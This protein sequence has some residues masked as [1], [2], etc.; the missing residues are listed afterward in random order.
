MLY[1]DAEMYDEATMPVVVS[2][3]AVKQ[4]GLV[5]ESSAVH[6]QPALAMH[7]PV[8]S[9]AQRGSE[10]QGITKIV[11]RSQGFATLVRQ[12][13]THDRS[14][15]ALFIGGTIQGLQAVER[16]TA[17]TLLRLIHA[18]SACSLG[19][20]AFRTKLRLAVVG[21]Y[22]ANFKAEREVRREREWLGL[23]IGCE[24]HMVSGIH[25]KALA[26]F[27]SSISG[28]I[29]LSLSMDLAG[30]M[31]K[32]RGCLRKVILQRVTWPPL[33]G[34]PS[35]EA[36]RYRIHAIS[37][38]VVGWG[39]AS[40]LQRAAIL[41][42]LPMGDWRRT[43]RVEVDLSLHH[44]ELPDKKAFLT[45]FADS[46]ANGLSW[47]KSAKYPRH[48]WFGAEESI[49]QPCLMQACHGLLAPAYA[50]FCKQFDKPKVAS[51]SVISLILP[52]PP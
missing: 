4:E 25:T 15:F 14:G 40:R 8:Q 35:S 26:C 43:D 49:S 34:E 11:Q 1:I 5:S 33:R 2:T 3:A 24:V 13:Q 6:A 20:K 29:H 27:D 39:R 36:K 23:A 42:A 30:M 32:F 12:R 7:Q 51:A 17:E 37:S 16:T 28:A 31:E 45:R 47:N 18:R 46:L 44:T 52:R 22:A 50:E 9:D 48:R 21:R 41:L 38:L 10:E 19:A